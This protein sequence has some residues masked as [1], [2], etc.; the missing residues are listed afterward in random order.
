MIVFTFLMSIVS[1]VFAATLIDDTAQQAQQEIVE[2]VVTRYVYIIDRKTGSHEEV[3]IQTES[4]YDGLVCNFQKGQLV[5]TSDAQAV[6]MM[7]YRMDELNRLSAIQK[8][9]LKPLA[10]EQLTVSEQATYSD[11][12]GKF[13]F[14]VVDESLAPAPQAGINVDASDSP[15]TKAQQFVNSMYIIKNLVDN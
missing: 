3:K 7:G 11:L 1:N 4:Q 10:F 5:I 13:N 12:K 8:V 14:F 6:H 2:P 9:S 15:A